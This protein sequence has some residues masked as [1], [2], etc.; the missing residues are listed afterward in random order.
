MGKAYFLRK[1]LTEIENI[2]EN[3]NF[4]RV[5]RSIILN[6]E[7]IKEIDYKEEY[8]LTKSDQKIYLGKQILKKISENYF[9]SF[10][11]L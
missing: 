9:S 5:E 3:S 6:I 7:Q 4:V 10:F 11:R 1:S 2:V 8:I